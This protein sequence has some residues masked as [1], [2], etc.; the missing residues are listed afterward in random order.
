MNL[1]EEEQVAFFSYLD[2]LQ[3]EAAKREWEAL[4][5][6][7]RMHTAKPRPPIG[8]R[9]PGVIIRRVPLIL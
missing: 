4:P 9:V 7:K 3:Y 2:N 1:S 5:W 6:W 8:I